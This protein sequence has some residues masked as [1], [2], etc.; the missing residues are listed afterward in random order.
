MR[1]PSWLTAFARSRRL[2]RDV[3]R[4][5]VA[6]ERQAAAL[7]RLADEFAP[8]LPLPTPDEIR[9]AGPLPAA[10]RDEVQGKI[11]DFTDR[12]LR[13]LQR[14][15]TEEEILQMLDETSESADPGEPVR[16]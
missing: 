11:L 5:A 15:P 13:D 4:I 1:A 6:A 14:E 12:M 10:R 3:G 9:T 16:H 8:A 2:L 7:E